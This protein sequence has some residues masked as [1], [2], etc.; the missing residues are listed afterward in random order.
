VQFVLDLPVAADGVAEIGGAGMVGGQGGHG[1]GGLGAPATG[2]AAPTADHLDGLSGVG[3]QDPGAYGG[4]FH[5]AALDPA[6]R[7][8]SAA[9]CDLAPVSMAGT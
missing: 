7:V 4:G 1:V 9:V 5:G 6:V 8:V 2:S 3:K